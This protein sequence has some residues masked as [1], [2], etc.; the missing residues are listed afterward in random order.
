M[1]KI[2]PIVL[3]FVTLLLAASFARAESISYG[4]NIPGVTVNSPYAPDWNSFTFYGGTGAGTT[5]V[6]LQSLPDS[7]VTALQS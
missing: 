2:S 5:T 3:C 1:T 6:Q 4:Y 7:G